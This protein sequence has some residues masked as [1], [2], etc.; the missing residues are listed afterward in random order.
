[1]SADGTWGLAPVT[2]AL[3]GKNVMVAV[4][5]DDGSTIGMVVEVDGLI[6]TIRDELGDLHTVDT[7]DGRRIWVRAS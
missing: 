4:R 1:M 6:V 3:V 2:P 7:G 5:P